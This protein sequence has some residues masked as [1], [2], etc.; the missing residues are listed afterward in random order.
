MTVG[1]RYQVDGRAPP[2]LASL[3]GSGSGLLADGALRAPVVATAMLGSELLLSKSATLFG[4][5]SAESGDADQR[6][7]ARVGVKVA[8]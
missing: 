8:F 2:A 7:A 3:S 5:V 1:L 6:A 4:A